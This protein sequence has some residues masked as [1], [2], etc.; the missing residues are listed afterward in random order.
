MERTHSPGRSSA[1]TISYV[2]VARA[3]NLSHKSV[4]ESGAA[5]RGSGIVCVPPNLIRSRGRKHRTRRERRTMFEPGTQIGRYEIQRRLGRGGMGT[6]YAAHDPVLGRLVASRCSQETLIFQMR[7]SALR[8]KRVQPLLWHIP[9]SSRCTTSASTASQP[10]IVMEYVAGE[11]LAEV[12]R[13]K[14]PVSLAEKLRWMEELAGGRR[15]RAPDVGHSPR[16]QAG[17][18]D[19]RPHRATE[20]SRLR[21]RANAGHRIEHEAT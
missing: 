11:T 6:V 2:C 20:D 19:H 15:L 8:A 10:Y 3:R 9:T 4:H 14:A 18:P 5:E 21:D 7:A 1:G 12:I 17:E 16:H 13:R